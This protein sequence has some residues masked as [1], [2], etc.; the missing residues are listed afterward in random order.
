MVAG[1][2]A[3]ASEEL[4]ESPSQPVPYLYPPSTSLDLYANVI[5]CKSLPGVVTRHKDIDILIVRENTEGEYSSLEHEVGKVMG[6]DGPA[7]G[8]RRLVPATVPPVCLLARPLW[9]DRLRDARPRQDTSL[10]PHL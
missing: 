10:V 2:A 8:T 9:L 1:A 7:R 5:H 4:P 3:G 6:W